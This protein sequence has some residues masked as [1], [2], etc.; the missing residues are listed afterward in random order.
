MPGQ[1]AP[2]LEC[3]PQYTKAAGLLPGQGA[4]KNQPMDA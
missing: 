2:L 1:V 4:R 3:C